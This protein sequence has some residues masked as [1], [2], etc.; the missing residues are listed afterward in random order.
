MIAERDPFA[1]VY[2]MPEE[3]TPLRNHSRWPALAGTMNL[4]AS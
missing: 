1:L 4:P 3:T 2:A